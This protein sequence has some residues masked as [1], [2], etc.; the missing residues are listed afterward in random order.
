[1]KSKLSILS[2][3]IGSDK[4]GSQFTS[5]KFGSVTVNVRTPTIGDM[6]SRVS[7]SRHVMARLKN[8]IST[9]GVKLTI[10][11]TTPTYTVDSSDP[12][13]VVQKIGNKKVR[14]QFKKG[15]FKVIAA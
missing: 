11:K 1:M 12:D 4:D 10:K 9:P 3:S 8:A 6:K 15:K 5:V 2:K 14:G 13:L 7:E